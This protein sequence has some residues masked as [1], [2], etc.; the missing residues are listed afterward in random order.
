MKTFIIVILGCL[1][2]I[3][4]LL[5]ISNFAVW[6]FS[7]DSSCPRISFKN[8]KNFYAIAPKKWKFGKQYLCYNG[9]VVEFNSYI[10]V[11]KYQRFQ[12]QKEKHEEEMEK[13]MRQ[14]AF[15][16]EI[17]KD[18]DR[19]RGQAAEETAAA[20]ERISIKEGNK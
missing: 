6:Y 7:R 1:F 8:F 18:I 10:D 4:G 17:Q 19:Y 16:E 20:L 14:A 9:N 12:K 13:N 5:F 3:F 2:L 15:L 11:M